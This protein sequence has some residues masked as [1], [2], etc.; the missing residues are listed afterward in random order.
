MAAPP[1]AINTFTPTATFDYSLNPR[2]RLSFTWMEMI[3]EDNIH[4]MRD[5]FNFSVTRSF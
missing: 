4:K 1:S 5:A 3:D 2:Y